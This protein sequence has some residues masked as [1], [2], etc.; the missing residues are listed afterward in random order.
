VSDFAFPE[1][2]TPPLTPEERRL[3]DPT[4]PLSEFVASPDENVAEALATAD[5]GT[6]APAGGLIF[7]AAKVGDG[8][9]TF[10]V[11]FVLHASA[12]IDFLG[13]SFPRPLRV[14][15][16]E[17]EGP[18]EAFRQ[19]LEARLTHWDGD[20]EPRIWDVPAEWGQVRVSDAAIRE[21]LRA[22]V[23]EHRIDLVVSDSLTRFGVRGNGT[24][25][26]TREFVEWLAELGL[27]RDLAFLLLHHPRTRPDPRRK[28]A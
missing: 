10:T 5:E 22:V 3:T 14:L 9:T 2:V 6:L 7:L 8:K 27:G 11:Q 21:R 23:A 17:N 4:V 26:E 25:E 18:R 16:I 19:K 12:G 1:P 28:R 20:G 15:I 24:P 13:M